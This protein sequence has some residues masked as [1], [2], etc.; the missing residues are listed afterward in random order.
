MLHFAEEVAA[1]LDPP[2][3]SGNLGSRE[4]FDPVR[5]AHQYP[6]CLT[7]LEEA[8]ALVSDRDMGGTTPGRPG[9]GVRQNRD[10]RT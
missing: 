10:E 3:G 6:F 9:I 1:L 5:Q 7:A 2:Q 4:R 8:V